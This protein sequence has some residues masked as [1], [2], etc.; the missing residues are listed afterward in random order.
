MKIGDIKNIKIAKKYSNALIEAATENNVLTKVY[1]DLI[2][3]V[4]TINTNSQLNDFLTSPLIKLQDKKDV[5]SKIFSI[6]I[7]KTTLDFL[8]V[9]ADSNR[10][11]AIN[12]ILN[13]FTIEFNKINNIARP[14]IT[15]AVE[16]DETQKEQLIQKLEIKLSKRVIPEYKID[17]NIIGGLLIEL[18]D[19]TIDCSLKTKFDNMKKQLTKGNRYG[20]D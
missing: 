8:L 10:L 20:S 3:V 16:L 7:N 15:S 6:H 14:Y 9:I 1:E 12:E 11:D 4:E 19:K 18:D 17:E 13:Q 5:I 2:F